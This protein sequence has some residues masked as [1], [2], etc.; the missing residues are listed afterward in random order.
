MVSSAYLRL[1]IFLLA[2]L[3]PAFHMMYSTYKLNKQ[4]WQDTALIYSFPNLESAYCSMSSSNWCFL[5]CKQVSQETGMVGWYSHLFKNFPQ[6]AVIHTVKGFSMVNEAEADVFLEFPC[7][8]YDPI[9]VDN[10]ISCS[11]A[12]S[13]PCLY[14]W[15]FFNSCE[16]RTSRCTCWVSFLYMQ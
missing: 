2:T 11:S 6:L 12:S 15:K 14:M 13:K 1:L 16:L 5:T 10:L 9:N 3:I 8:L 4:G 7:F